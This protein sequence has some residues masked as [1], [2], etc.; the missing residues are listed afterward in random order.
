MINPGPSFNTVASFASIPNDF[1]LTYE[2]RDEFA[3][4]A[5]RIVLA[6][7]KNLDLSY[8]MYEENNGKID[9]TESS[10][11]LTQQKVLELYNLL[12]SNNYFMMSGLYTTK[13]AVPVE[14]VSVT[15][16]S[17]DFRVEYHTCP[18]GQEV[19]PLPAGFSD[20]VTFI[21]VLSENE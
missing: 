8:E 5:Y 9:K 6:I 13:A 17:T 20:I 19:V 3:K 4:P 15:A 1:E 14:Y 16:K 7:D 18:D 10:I 12:V 2:I 11:K 21:L